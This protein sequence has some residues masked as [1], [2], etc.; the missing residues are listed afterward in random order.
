MTIALIKKIVMEIWTDDEQAARS[1]YI[2]KHRVGIEKFIM[3]MNITRDM[4]IFKFDLILH[5]HLFRPVMD[6]NAAMPRF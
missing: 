6:Y 2:T 3:K 5:N 4:L 1:I